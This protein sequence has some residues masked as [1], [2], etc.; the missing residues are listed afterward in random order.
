MDIN[1]DQNDIDEMKNNGF[2]VKELNLTDMNSFFA[3][4]IEIKY[5]LGEL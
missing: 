5:T 1:K 4:K 3:Y 2:K